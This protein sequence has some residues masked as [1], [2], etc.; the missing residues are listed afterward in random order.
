[1]Q[2]LS[3]FDLT[4]SGVCVVAALLLVERWDLRGKN[5]LIWRKW[6]EVCEKWLCQTVCVLPLEWC[7]GDFGP[8]MCT[9]SPFLKVCSITSVLL[10]TIRRQFPIYWRL[11][12]SSWPIFLCILVQLIATAAILIQHASVNF[13]W[14]LRTPKRLGMTDFYQ[15]T[16]SR[17]KR[18]TYLAYI[19][20][21]KPTFSYFGIWAGSVKRTMSNLR[22]LFSITPAQEKQGSL[23]SK[24][25]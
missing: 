15:L 13:T 10:A 19:D 21:T 20:P 23:N 6:R 14:V 16:E 5:F 18:Q 11:K 4:R 12:S 8:L 25:F 24:Y 1:M 17:P 2:L 3:D 22:T 7:A 9:F